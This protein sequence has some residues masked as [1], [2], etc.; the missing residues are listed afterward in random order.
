LKVRE[1]KVRNF[2][3][4][5]RKTIL[6]FFVEKRKEKINNVFLGF[7]SSYFISILIKIL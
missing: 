6:G 3:F 2:R 1:I 7:I 4:R 5:E